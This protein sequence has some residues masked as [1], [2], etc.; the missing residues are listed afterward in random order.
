MV[1]VPLYWIAALHA[2]ATAAA[3]AGGVL[4][5]AVLRSGRRNVPFYSDASQRDPERVFLA[6]FENL[7]CALLPI[8]AAGERA[9]HIRLLGTPLPFAARVNTVAVAFT[10]LCFFITANVPTLLPWTPLH[11]LAAS[12]LLVG[13]SVQA[14]CKMQ[15][16]NATR[17]KAAPRAIRVAIAVALWGAT[18][19]V[20]MCFAAR[21]AAPAEMRSFRVYALPA[22][23]SSVYVATVASVALMV[24]LAR[25]LRHE[26]LVFSAV[27]PPLDAKRLDHSEPSL[28]C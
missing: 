4:L 11:Q 3:T 7:A 5:V 25:D 16:A 21:T 18:A 28:A 19:A 10:A 13:Y 15:I 14:V 17:S 2:G 23:A 8:V 20:F 24:V 27:G 22:M 9:Q 1:R 26:S 12:G 6:V